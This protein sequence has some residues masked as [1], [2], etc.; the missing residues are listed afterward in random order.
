MTNFC[1]HCGSQSAPDQRFC[2]SC[3]ASLD[4]ATIPI[5]RSVGQGRNPSGTATPDMTGRSCPYCRFPLKEGGQVAECGSCHAVH[6][7]DC[8]HENGG[9]AVAGC[10]SGP[11]AQYAAP[12]QAVPVPPPTAAPVARPA[13][14][15]SYVPPPPTGPAAPWAP[16]PPTG[17]PPTFVERSSPVTLPPPP[18]PSYTTPRGNRRRSTATIAILAGL[19]L[20]ALGGGATA[21]VVSS[22]R[23]AGSA[24]STSASGASSDTSTSPSPDTGTTPS[25][26]TGT[27]PIPV[28]P[29]TTADTTPTTSP[30]STPA[31][32]VLAAINNHWQDIQNGD[33]HAAFQ[34]LLPSADGNSTESTWVDS[35]NQDGI[36]SVNFHFTVAWVNGDRARV[37]VDSLTTQDATGCHS[38]GGHYLML[39]QGGSWL[40]AQVFLTAGG[41]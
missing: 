4:P 38:F 11:T 28:V 19:I 40:I 3:G 12:T 1:S 39:Q 9:C 8:Y 41:C 37:N 6:H 36:T 10:T 26:D 32:D 15:P 13:R 27:T 29:P 35:H 22:G 5:A 20:L 18:P 33:Y 30:S 23:H 25:A 24:G 14:R 21:L 17:P 31:D 7:E 2:T 16:P 34:L